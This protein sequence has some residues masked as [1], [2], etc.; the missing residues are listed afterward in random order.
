MINL[1]VIEGCPFCHKADNLLKSLKLRVNKTIVS[2]NDKCKYKKM[3]K[4][5]TFPQ[6]IY[7]A[8]NNRYKIGGYEELEYL[9]SI[10]ELKKKF[11]FNSKIISYFERNI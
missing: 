11:K 4:M 5:N 9:L 3:N 6:I 2:N 7:T 8:N 10:V 1:Y